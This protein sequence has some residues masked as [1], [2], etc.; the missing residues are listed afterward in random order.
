VS[1]HFL[2][3]SI[4][5]PRGSQGGVKKVP[6]K[7]TFTYINRTTRG[8]GGSKNPKNRTTQFLDAPFCHI[9][10]DTTTLFLKKLKAK[11]LIFQIGNYF[12]ALLSNIKSSNICAQHQFVPSDAKAQNSDLYRMIR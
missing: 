8:G 4:Q 2:F 10:I 6:E 12:W 3:G 9:T 7:T 1:D 5:K 11:F